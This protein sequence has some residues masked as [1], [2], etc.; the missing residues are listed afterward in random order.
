MH[1]WNV[2]EYNVFTPDGIANLIFNV[3]IYAIFLVI[4][5]FTYAVQVENQI[6][7]IQ[8]NDIIGDITTDI[9]DVITDQQAA[10]LR[11]I[12]DNITLPDLSSDDIV[13]EKSNANI[14]KYSIIAI[15]VFT[16]LCILSIILMHYFY[17]IDISHNIVKNFV[18]LFFIAIT[19]ILFLNF[20]SKSYKSLDPNVVKK[21]IIQK[22]QSM[23]SGDF[24]TPVLI[25][26]GYM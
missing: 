23:G 16:A 15:S 24:N 12:L 4:F 19:E 13:V 2:E 25:P 21:L 18:I 20:V 9:K 26:T 5:Y 6:L 10:T 17:K 14:L 7:D 22:I 1:T 11:N 3:N 8:I